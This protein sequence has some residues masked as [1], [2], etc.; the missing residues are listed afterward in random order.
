MP[1]NSSR[2]PEPIASSALRRKR[3]PSRASFN[4]ARAPRPLGPTVTPARSFAGMRA[5]SA[6][7]CASA[8]LT[9]TPMSGTDSATRSAPCEKTSAWAPSAVRWKPA[10]NASELT[11]ARAVPTSSGR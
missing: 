1:R 7:S 8:L 4:K 11:T 6:G 3:W 10:R 9:S 5:T 2:P